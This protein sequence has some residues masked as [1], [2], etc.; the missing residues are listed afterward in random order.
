MQ[1]LPERFWRRA[2]ILTL[3]LGSTVAI[4]WLIFGGTIA[5][6]GPMRVLADRWL[7]IY[8]SQA[9]LAGLVGFALANRAPRTSMDG[10][11]LVVAVAWIGEGLVLTLGG[12]LLANELVPA[13][14]WFYWLIGTRGVV[15]PVAAVVGAGIGRTSAPT[16]SA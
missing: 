1:R 8:A 12:T 5:F 13:V 2:L 9:L 6:R 10:M 11:G 15:Q 3:A 16:A 4:S 14:A 7:L